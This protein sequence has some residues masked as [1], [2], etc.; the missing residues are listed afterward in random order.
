[1]YMTKNHG[2]QF[3]F[4]AGLLL[5]LVLTACQSASVR[6]AS[7]LRPLQGYWE[8]QGPGGDFFSVTISEN[9]LFYQSRED[10][11][12]DTTFTLPPATG[13]DQLHATIIKDH[14][15]DQDL[16]DTVVVTIF[17]IEGDSLTLGVV[18]DFKGPPT[19]SIVGDWDYVSDIFYLKKASPPSKD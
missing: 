2:K 9:S 14:S 3:F 19:E 6:P 18:E 5:M 16:V 1:M 12:F 8:G 4:A 7:D 11:W 17:K 15:P 13:P 10:F